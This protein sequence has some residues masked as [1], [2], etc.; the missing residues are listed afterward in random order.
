MD[1]A[2]RGDGIGQAVLEALADHGLPARL[3]HDGEQDVV[4]LADGTRFGLRS[5][6]QVAGQADR[7]QWRGL[8]ERWAVMTLAA[9]LR[10]EPT[11]MSA[12]E[13]RRH[14][15]TRLISSMHGGLDPY[16]YAR[17]TFPLVGQILC[18]DY[19]ETV[20]KVDADMAGRLALPTAELFG[21][22]QANTDAEPFEEHAALDD[23][24]GIW[25]IAGDSL[26]IA[27]KAANW[28]ALVP[29]VT[30][31]APHGL[32]FSLPRSTAL[33][34]QVVRDGWGRAAARFAQFAFALG[35]QAAQEG[36]FVSPYTYYC[37]PT[38]RSSSCRGRRPRLRG[39]R[40]RSIPAPLSARM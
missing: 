21:R 39:P 37:S 3:G 22:G 40:W 28:G 14:V 16:P 1:D 6:Y 13:L 7:A 10:T 25:E 5:L 20:V 19:P 4:E 11:A 26:F 35:R 27:S 32:I 17:R 31:P 34:Y 9:P 29:G 18:V 24:G 30:G 8:A 2:N 33:I 15:R 36:D 12:D 38:A 23:E